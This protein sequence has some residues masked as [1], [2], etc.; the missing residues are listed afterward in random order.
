MKEPD[1]TPDA[2]LETVGHLALGITS[3]TANECLNDNR[4]DQGNEEERQLYSSKLKE[5][6][7]KWMLVHIEIPKE[8]KDNDEIN[9][10]QEEKAKQVGLG[11]EN[12]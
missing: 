2:V 12:R 4:G 7:T 5:S 1:D 3:T 11:W 9:Q 10:Q 6:K 8:E